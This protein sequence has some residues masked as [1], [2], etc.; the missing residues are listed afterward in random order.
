[1]DDPALATAAITPLL[2]IGVFLGRYIVIGL[3]AGSGK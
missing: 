2:L 3:T 1:V